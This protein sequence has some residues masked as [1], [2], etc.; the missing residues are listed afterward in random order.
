M[1]N[2]Q[3]EPRVTQKELHENPAKVFEQAARGQVVIVDDDD[4]PRAI[5]SAP[6]DVR[7]LMFE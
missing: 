5:L 2:E 6:T 3:R 1:S 7:P 4:Q